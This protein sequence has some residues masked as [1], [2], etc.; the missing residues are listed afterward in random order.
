MRYVQIQKFIE[1][2]HWNTQ[3]VEKFVTGG[4][5]N[6]DKTIIFFLFKKKIIL[7]EELL[8]VSGQS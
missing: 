5:L 8:L 2:T 1:I 6:I 3:N 4:A 7:G